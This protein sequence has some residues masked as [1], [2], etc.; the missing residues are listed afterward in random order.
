MYPQRGHRPSEELQRLLDLTS[1]VSWRGPLSR[2]K[3]IARMDQAT[4][5][6]A[7]NRPELSLGQD[8]M[9]FYDYS[10]RG[11]PIVS[12]NWFAA[13]TET[14]PGLRVANSAVDFAR[15][16]RLAAISDDLENQ[17][18]RDWAG[19]HTWTRRWGA[20]SNAVLGTRTD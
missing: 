10:A 15:C 16:V 3:S 9:K 2:S 5:A 11:M 6:I 13:D 18:R 8:S 4:V 1:Q 7:P 20:W 14:P 19:E 17:R 12:T